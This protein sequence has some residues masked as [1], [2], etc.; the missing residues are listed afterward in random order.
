MSTA[1]GATDRKLN[2][3]LV[4]E[5]NSID[6]EAARR[7]FRKTGIPNEIDHAWTAEEALDYL[8]RPEKS[9]PS[10]ILLDLNLPGMGGRKALEIIK[11]DE[12]FRD[13]PVIVLT[14]SNYGQDIESCYN[15]GANTFIQKPVD[16]DA[17]CKDIHNV[18]E[19]WL[20]TALLPPLQDMRARTNELEQAKIAAERANQAKTDFLANMSHELRTPLNSVMGMIRLLREDRSIAD[21]QRDMLGVA[22]RASESLLT[23]VNDILDLAKVESGH[24]ELESITFSLGEVVDGV[25]EIIAPMC[26]DKGLAFESDFTRDNLPY[27]VGD[28]T[29]LSRVMINLLGN[30]VK[31]TERGRVFYNVKCRPDGAGRIVLD[32]SVTDTGIGIAADKLHQI[33][34]KFTQ[35]DRSIARRYGGTGLGLNITKQIV[36][37]MDGRVGVESVLGKGSRFWVEIPFRTALKR[38]VHDDDLVANDDARRLPAAQ[39]LHAADA[40]LLVAE[41]YLMNQAYMKKLLP[42]LGF[43]RFH[44]VTDGEEA[45]RQGASGNYDLILMDCHMPLLNGYDAT[46]AIRAV[47][48]PGQRIPI[49]AMTADAILGTRERCLSAGMDEYIAKPLDPRAFRRVVGKWITFPE[50]CGSDCDTAP[51]P[52]VNLSGLRQFADSEEEIRE[53]V[54]MFLSQA[55]ESLATL[56]ALCGEDQSA[57]WSEAAHKF[58]GGAAMLRAERLAALCSEAQ[59]MVDPSP[60]ARERMLARIRDAYAEVRQDLEQLAPQ[61]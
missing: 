11:G 24:M 61:G 9:S 35:A 31:Y 2:P 23:I 58:K 20:G 8:G 5:D 28:P 45:A 17:L 51:P 49:V 40:R 54:G 60:Y 10:L 55:E 18:V 59:E 56:A 52:S 48:P 42:Q 32:F 12:N 4:V 57:E 37:K 30:A 3:I 6:L 14:T 1:P 53:L 38:P 39:R 43:R 34:G 46:T 29:R 41:D 33:F 36:E 22:F 50:E 21:E 44:F 47:E 27:L 13:I 19:Y 16:F 26:D 15:L 25:Q 7:A